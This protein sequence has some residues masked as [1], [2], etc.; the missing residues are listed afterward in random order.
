MNTDRIADQLKAWR[1]ACFYEAEHTRDCTH[2]LKSAAAG[3]A[4]A[5]AYRLIVP[6]GK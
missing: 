4:Y 6:M 1:D 3:E 5:R 2:F